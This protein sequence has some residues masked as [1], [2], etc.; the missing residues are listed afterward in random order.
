MSDNASIAD[1]RQGYPSASGMYRLAACPGSWQ[2][3]SQCPEEPESDAAAEGTLIH[4]ALAGEMP[5]TDLSDDQQ[6]CFFRCREQEFRLVSQF[7]GDTEMVTI[8]EHRYWYE[9][10][11]DHGVYHYSG[12]PDV[13]HLEG[14]TALVIDYKTG[15]VAVDDA[16]GNWQL[17]ALALAVWD[18]HPAVEV[19][20]AAII[21]PRVAEQPTAVVYSESDLRQAAVDIDALFDAVYSVDAPL[22]AGDHCKWC[23]GKSVC[24]KLQNAALAVLPAQI[25]TPERIKA[26]APQL[27]GQELA[28]ILPKAEVAQMYIDAVK[29][30][31]KQLLLSGGEIPGYELKQGA[32]RREITDPAQ[33]FVAVSDTV[34]AAEFAGCCTVKIGE[35]E[36]V[37]TKATGLKKKDAKAALAEVLGEVLTTKQSAPSLARSTVAL[38]SA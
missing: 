16:A 20:V 31:A 5:Y 1:P 23:R 19:V 10:G 26:T 34:T 11:H 9:W 38:Q 32:S 24:P 27:T 15:R 36:E 30:H 29:A 33:A 28:A 18:N 35:L 25:D 6:S 12:Q 22:V 4:R 8:R 21:Q 13:V 14:S 2:I 3:E 17:R 7:F 37:Y